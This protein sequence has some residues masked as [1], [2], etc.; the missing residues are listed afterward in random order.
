MQWMAQG[1]ILDNMVYF[2]ENHDEQRIASGFFCGRGACAEPAMITVATLYKN[3]VLVY[4]GQELGERGMDMEGFSGMDGRTTIFDYW[5]V[6]SLQAWANRG[7]FDG[8]GL[9]DEQQQL[10]GF[11]QRLLTLARDNKAINSGKMYDLEYAQN[12]GFNKH[13]QYAYLRKAGDEVLLVALNFDD[14]QVDMHI[15]IPADAFV[16]MEQE[17]IQRADAVDL[18]T[19]TVYT[20]LTFTALEPTCITLPAWKGAILRITPK[21]AHKTTTNKNR[22]TCKK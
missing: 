4:A 5:G 1:D 21:M 9:D 18:L 16:Y 10:R 14:R 2:L 22:K 6:K 19:D 17:E 7:K 13:E 15:N 3:P 8:A 12:G 20:N 11:Y